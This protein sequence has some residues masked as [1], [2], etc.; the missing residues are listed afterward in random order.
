[1]S[2]IGGTSVRRAADK[3]ELLDTLLR[4]K[5][6]GAFGTYRDALVFAAAVG[7]RRRRKQPVEGNAGPID[8]GTMINRFG[9]EQLVD[10]LAF[11]DSGDVDILAP[12]RL[13]ERVRTFESYANGGLEVISELMGVKALSGAEAVYELLREALDDHHVDAT[14]GPDL[15]DLGK[16]LGL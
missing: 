2:D 12:S 11:E 5:D 15:R 8:W 13:P 6:G 1:M 4:S 7:W 3:A 16:A 10:V 9:T 14:D